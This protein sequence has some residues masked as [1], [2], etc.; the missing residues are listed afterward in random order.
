MQDP[1]AYLNFIL[2][3]SFKQALHKTG[4]ILLCK[5]NKVALLSQKSAIFSAKNI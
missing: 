3:Y 1:T 4:A 5:R 2:A